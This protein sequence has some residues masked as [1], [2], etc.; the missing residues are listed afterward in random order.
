ME[1]GIIA[2]LKVLILKGGREGEG[3]VS[4]ECLDDGKK[5]RVKLPQ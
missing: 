1:A 3:I 4:S 2:R 5:R